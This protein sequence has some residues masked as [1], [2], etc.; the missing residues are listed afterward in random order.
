MRSIRLR[1]NIND[2]VF[3]DL[4]SFWNQ[5]LFCIKIQRL[6]TVNNLRKAQG[7]L[8]VNWPLITALSLTTSFC[9]LV[10]YSYYVN[11]DPLKAGVISASDQ[12]NNFIMLP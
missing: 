12:V 2:V 10:M 7:A 6:L 11:C 1:W 4:K 9:G 3:I 5:L 8:W